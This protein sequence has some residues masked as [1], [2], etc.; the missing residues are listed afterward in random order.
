[1]YSGNFIVSACWPFFESVVLAPCFVGL[2]F[3]S[4][5]A[6]SFLHLFRLQMAVAFIIVL[7]NRMMLPVPVRQSLLLPLLTNNCFQCRHQRMQIK[8]NSY[9]R[10]ERERKKVHDEFVNI[11]K[12]KQRVSFV[13]FCNHIREAAAAF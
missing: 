8:G 10:G 9:F 4:F 13:L 11:Y 3:V 5:S 6:L 7:T 2:F 1:L 12:T